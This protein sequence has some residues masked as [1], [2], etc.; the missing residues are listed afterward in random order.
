MQNNSQE[1]RFNDA[2]SLVL[3]GSRNYLE[4][5]KI[6]F[7]Q[8]IKESDDPS[9]E[10]NYKRWL[11]IVDMQLED[12]YNAWKE[13]HFVL[14]ALEKKNGVTFKVKLEKDTPEKLQSLVHHD[15][16][17]VLTELKIYEDAK[18][19][20]KKSIE[21]IEKEIDK[22][23][24]EKTQKDLN[25]T[26]AWYL[27]DLGWLYY[28][29]GEYG[30]SIEQYTRV[31]KNLNLPN[32]YPMGYPLLYR[33]LAQYAFENKESAK[34][35]F[36]ESC[37]KF[38]SY[39]ESISEKSTKQR[40]LMAYADAISN[41]A[42]ID[43]DNMNYSGAKDKL[44]EAENIYLVNFD[45]VEGSY[46]LRE[47][48][49]AHD[50]L[51]SIHNLMGK[52]YYLK[53]QNDEAKKRFE[54]ARGYAKSELNKA[55]YYNN[56][57]CIYQKS[58][59][60]DK[61]RKYYLDAIKECP[62]W[63]TPQDNLAEILKLPEKGLNILGYWIEG[64]RKCLAS[65]LF[66]LLLIAIIVPPDY[67]NLESSIE[68]TNEISFK[69]AT[70]SDFTNLAPSIIADEG[71]AAFENLDSESFKNSDV[72]VDTKSTS[73]KSTSMERRYILIALIVLILIF[74]VL[75]SIKTGPLE[76]ELQEGKLETGG[77]SPLSVSGSVGA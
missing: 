63:K 58:N 8:L 60:L 50:N 30:N 4:R 52:Y 75:K 10:L 26:L 56:V 44:I 41:L 45:L 24:D 38:L 53:D 55:R 74:P 46:S 17:L 49:K 71:Y 25:G 69:N 70:I 47:Y 12:Y 39:A 9:S 29:K 28:N 18:Y 66:V 61:A 40:T 19:N 76:I 37:K 5:A 21:I 64:N 59:D 6:E 65:I 31:I 42:R 51:S 57:G 16:G 54:I 33:G 67:L 43:L 15:L 72:E 68:S 3:K 77:A 7:N 11:G 1:K 34:S 62:S 27:N 23:P 48:K 73:K 36:L 35:D 13:F 20:L 22:N 2:C 32:D 14:C